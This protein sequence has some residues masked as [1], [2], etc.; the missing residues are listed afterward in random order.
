[1]ML[2]APG[3]VHQKYQDMKTCLRPD[4]GV[5]NPRDTTGYSCGLRLA[6]GANPSFSFCLGI[7]D[8]R[9]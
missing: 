9:N 8:S 7:P 3:F 5:E 6:L 4:G 2:S 1:M